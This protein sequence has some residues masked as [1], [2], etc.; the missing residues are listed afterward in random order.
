MFRHGQAGSDLAPATPSPLTQTV[1]IEN[2]PSLDEHGNQV[3]PRPSPS[4]T[5][6]SCERSQIEMVASSS[7]FVHASVLCAREYVPVKGLARVVCVGT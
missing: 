7:A 3:N 5:S 6:C 1:V 2:P 4:L